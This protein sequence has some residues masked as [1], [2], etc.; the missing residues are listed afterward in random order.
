MI[1]LSNGARGLWFLHR[2]E[3][4]NATYNVPLVLRCTGELDTAA[5]ATAVVDLVARHEI[6]RTRMPE[7]DGEPVQLVLDPAEAP[8]MTVH[9]SDPEQGPALLERLARHC[10]D[11]EHEPA[12]RAELVRTGPRE[13]ALLLLAHHVATDGWSTTPLVHDLLTAYTARTAGS[14]PGWAEL[15]VQYGDYVLWQ[16]ELLGDQ[17]DEHSLLR[18]QLEHW[19]RVLDGAPEL[20]ALPTD[21]PRPSRPSRRGARTPL[22]VDASLRTAIAA[23]AARTR[24]TEFMVL[25]AALA[26]LLDRLG[27]GTDLPIGTSVAGRTEEGLDQLVGYFVNTLVLRTDT[28]GAPCFTEL[29]ARVRETDLAAYANQD[30]PFERLIHWLNPRRG[31]GHQP[32]SQIVLTMEDNATEQVRLGELTVRTEF[33]GT[34]AAKFDLLFL[35]APDAETGEIGGYLQYATELFDEETARSI[36][37]R[38]Q[39]LLAG[40][41][42]A[43]DRGID[44]AAVLSP[45]ERAV[46]LAAPRPRRVP[47]ED[48]ASAF[49]ERVHAHPD[50]IALVAGADGS[51]YTYARLDRVAEALAARLRAEDVRAEE[52]VAVRLRRGPRLVV[53]L[54]AV[55]KAGAAYVPLHESFP[56]ARVE[57]I[58]RD[59]GARLLLRDPG[60]EGHAGLR[61]LD[62]PAIED[63]EGSGQPAAPAPVHPERLAYVMY[64]SGSTGRPKG[65]AVTHADIL[66]LVSD[67]AWDG[68]TARRVLLHSSHAFD[69]S[70]FELWPPLLRGGRIICAPEGD[71]DPG[72]YRSLFAEYRPTAVF[73]TTALFELLAEDQPDCFAPV[74]Q[75][76]QGGEQVGAD[77]LRRVLAHCADT[78]LV[79]VYGPTETTTFATYQAIERGAE[80]GAPVPIGRPMDNR[81]ASVLDA[82]LRPVPPGVPGE[83][84]LSGSGLARGYLGDP[85]RTAERFLADPFG[86]PGT[87]MYR[88][89]DLVRW[90]RHGRIEFLGRDDK[91]VKLRGFRIELG[92]IETVLAAQD[93]VA[94][95]LV[96]VH[97][98]EAGQRRL[99]AYVVPPSGVNPDHAGLRSAL[100]GALPEY[101]VPAAITVLGSFPLNSNGKI[102]HAL[103]PAPE[104]G[105]GDRTGRPVTTD[106]EIL[107][108]LFAETLGLSEVGT[109]DGFFA[110]GG[111]SLLVMRLVARIEEVFSV[112]LPLA[113][114]FTAQTPSAVAVAVREA[115]ATER[116]ALVAGPRPERPPLSI[117]ANRLWFV[118]QLDNAGPAYH[119]PFVLR[120]EGELDREALCAAADDVLAR[121][122]SLRTAFPAEDGQPY[123]LIS[124]P[125][126]GNLPVEELAPAAVRERISELVRAPFDIAASPPLRAA[127]LAMSARSH[128]FVLV[129]HHILADGESLSVLRSDL[130]LAYNARR[131]GRA[132]EFAPLPVQYADYALWQRATGT[133]GDAMLERW[134]ARLRGAPQQLNLPT[135]HPRPAHAD[136]RGSSVTAHLGTEL[137]TALAG[138]AARTGSTL[139]MVLHAGL[140]ILLGKLGA[141]HDLPIG[142][143]VSGRTEP[144]TAALAGFFVNTVV[145]RTD[146][147]GDPRGTELLE[148]VRELDRQ[149]L[150]DQ[151]V[152]FERLVEALNPVRS[153][154]R[155]PLFQVMLAFRAAPAHR[156]AFDGLTVTEQEAETGTAKFDLSF[157]LSEDRDETGA[158]AG[159]HCT[160]RYAS[161]LFEERSA[162]EIAERYLR[163][164]TQLAA[165][166]ERRISTIDVLSQ[167]EHRELRV[168]AEH[169][170]RA[171]PDTTLPELFLDQARRTPDAVAVRAGDSELS[172]AGLAARASALARYLREHGVREGDLVAVAVSRR[173]ELPVALLG[174]QLAGAAYLPLD[175]AHPARRLRFI[176]A[177]A[178]PAFLISTGELDL[179]SSIPC[180]RIDEHEPDGAGTA[181]VPIRALGP[182]YVIY[183]SG[184]TGRPKG[185]RVSQRNLVNFLGALGELVPL[186]AEERLLAV[187]TVAFDIA[188]LELYLPLISGATV[189]LADSEDVRDPGALA[190]LIRAERIST[191]QATPALWEALLDNDQQVVRGLRALVGGE[192]LPAPLAARLLATGSPVRNLYGP[193]ETTIWST[194]A[195]LE[196]GNDGQA[197]PIGTP[198][199]NT[200]AHVLDAALRPVP[201]RVP[202]ELYLAGD[203]VADGYLGRPG[204]TAGRFLADPFGPPGTRMYRTGDLALREPDGTLHYLGR[205]DQQVKIRGFRIELG[206]IEAELVAHPSVGRAAAAVHEDDRTGTRIIAY[207]TG[208]PGV[209]PEP[210]AVRDHLRTRLPDYMLPAQYTVLDE[211]P[212]NP[213]GKLDRGALPAPER[214]EGTDKT[215]PR[216]PREALLCGLFAQ[217]L[218]IEG[219]GVHEDFFALGGH[220]LLVTTLVGRIRAECGEIGIRDVFEAPTVAGL[221]ARAG[222]AGPPRAP[223]R[224]VAPALRGTL[225]FAQQRLWFLHQFEGTSVAYNI[226]LALRLDACPNEDALRAALADVVLRHESLRTIFP[227][228]DGRPYQQVVDIEQAEVPFENL[229]GPPERL[230]EAARYEFDLTTELPVRA[231]LLRGPRPILLLVLHHIAADEASLGPL[232]HDLG[233]AYTARNTGSAPSL[234]PLPVQY[235]D[236]AHWQR[237][238][239]GDR[240]DTGSALATELAY[241]REALRGLSDELALPTDRP[242]PSAATHRGG[243]VHFTVGAET[244]DRITALARA[245][246]ATGFMVVHAALAALL[247]RIGAGTDIAIGTAVDG[248]SDPALAQVAGF[249]VNS[250]V[251]RADTSGRPRFTEL[252]DRVREADLGAYAHQEVPFEQLVEE[253]NPD[254]SA[255]RHPLFQVTL[256]VTADGN[257]LEFAADGLHGEAEFVR[258]TMAKFDLSFSLAEDENGFAGTLEFATDLFDT[259]TANSLAER[260]SRLLGE[261]TAAP[262]RRI[263]EFD[264]LS[265]AERNT[266]LHTWNTT[267]D[268]APVLELPRLFERQVAETPTLPA[269]SGPEGELSYAGLNGRANRI[270]HHLIGLGFGPGDVLACCLPRGALALAA[271]LGIAKAG[272]AYLPVDP[273]YP[274]DRIRHMLTDA[275]PGRVLTT[276]ALARAVPTGTAR[277]LVL[278]DLGVAAALDRL[279]GT[280]PD[281]DDRVTPLSSSATAYVIYTSGSSGRPKGVAVSHSGIGNSLRSLIARADVRAGERYLHFVSL[282]FDVSL[283]EIGMALVSGA[284]LVIPPER[285]AGAELAAFLERE[286]IAHVMLPPSMLSALPESGLRGLRSVIT[287]GETFAGDLVE[288][289]APGRRMINA[290]GPTEATMCAT[291]SQPLRPGEPAP[292]GSP[293][294]NTRC[295]VLDGDLQPVPPGGTGELYLAGTGLA[296]GYL[297][298]PGQTADRFLANPFGGPGERM[299]RTGDLVRWEAGGAL[300]FIGRADEQVKI[301]GYRLELGEVE[302]VLSDQ[303]GV[304]MAAAAVLERATGEKQLVGYVTP[305]P[306]AELDP[307]T[308]RAGALATLPDYM[309]PT[310]YLVLDALPLTPNGKVDRAALPAPTEIQQPHTAPR[311]QREELLCGIYTEL[312]GR[313]EVGIDE[314]FFALGGDSIL[315]IQL[316]SRARKAGLR[317][318]A[319]DVFQRGTV[320]ELAALASAGAP[321]RDTD[322]NGTGPLPALPIMRWLHELDGVSPRFS[323]SMLLSVPAGLD[324]ER[325]TSALGALLDTHD[326]L[327]L[328]WPEDGEPVVLPKGSID[329]ASVLHVADAREHGRE[330][331]WLGEQGHAAWRQLDPA[332]GVMLRCVWFDRGSAGPGALLLVLHHAAVDGI[333]WRILLPDLRAAYEGAAPEAV[334]TSLRT[335]SLWLHEEALRPGRTAELT[336]WERALTV[337]TA[338]IGRRPLD[339][340]TDTAGRAEEFT[341]VL[342]AEQTRALLTTVAARFNAGIEDVLLTAFAVALGKA[343]RGPVLVDVEGHG[344]QTGLFEDVDLSRTVGWF[345][346]SYPLLLEPGTADPKQG[347]AL[348][349]ALKAVKEQVRAVPDRGIGYGLLRYLNEETAARLRALPGAAAGFNYLGRMATAGRNQDEPGDWSVL[350][351]APVPP[352][353]GP[354]MPA[355][356]AIDVNALTEDRADGPYLSVTWMWQPGVLDE[357]A[358]TRLAA[359]FDEALRTL[360][361]HTARPDSGGLTPSDLGM[362]LD[363]DE[364]LDLEAELGNPE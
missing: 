324:R 23:L 241:W 255:A 201:P 64:T 94:A 59:T 8:A 360:V 336:F 165:A 209:R 205:T 232:L 97:E 55:L 127:L 264:L 339:P 45:A 21:H 163:V 17:D 159:L 144:A 32:Y 266:V 92:E 106:E 170:T 38:Y 316:V 143:P 195:L 218:G 220:S 348:G 10:F 100:A 129:L 50:A 93:S 76:W 210:D 15:P 357:A 347:T 18:E 259:G 363:Q 111:H 256:A 233:I 156:A 164:L 80:L 52:P 279:P 295:Y 298:Q 148:R 294:P 167:A 135:D 323:Q 359:D 364:I 334:P 317:F 257:R 356:H 105:S 305:G 250:I 138:L 145:L 337:P 142:T 330:P 239:L 344:R 343:A 332:A 151:Q 14:E 216:G 28:S 6:L 230:W 272:A 224:T 208:A 58:L 283:A 211:L 150:A 293:I 7:V 56:R 101:M 297:N 318:S 63:S 71:L 311:D 310:E 284:C 292:I 124:R 362:T 355:V 265:A 254:R 269:L 19:H 11:L 268:D 27:A 108:A 158:P 96:T 173:A 29:L 69:A 54:L 82:R 104:F 237:T 171:V 136:Y 137:H 303:D 183:T 289:W 102:D 327:R 350:P 33:L 277:A 125:R 72:V 4:P 326:A 185:V 235:A 85:R 35:L 307:A 193:T 39:R 226:P 338:P 157:A 302:A 31:L 245:H 309:V 286:H 60:G 280:D 190:R 331:A 263:S 207:L 240:A 131:A 199:W 342:G 247:T 258:T 178:A 290:Y 88:T 194:T 168:A 204:L 134:C 179:D 40:L 189:V 196:H 79:H 44:E 227:D 180:L 37:E 281:D 117:A 153:F 130:A 91:Q 313:A 278:D 126:R 228:V 155:H 174:T 341:T 214:R 123:Q 160:L 242:R 77:G 9:D 87:R 285:L 192:A 351:G 107:C 53:A 322:E 1:P 191:L 75:V 42:H 329:P 260:F 147:S 223:L 2:L 83:L 287:G 113:E 57:T 219:C 308:L 121:H 267:E 346:T 34:G 43:P 304:G 115:N 353:Q 78:K 166:P 271:I 181:P 81:R 184:S 236:Y 335:W 90:T 276:R 149:A 361:E 99:A 116:P 177:D 13:H 270:A 249:F 340:R 319:A 198:L 291:L 172:Y 20:L 12:F 320:R 186:E 30:V 212:L 229:D 187:T 253:L 328:R 49:T 162:K 95:A 222:R 67:S 274:A 215:P 47:A 251:L 176:L 273:D 333:S 141:G 248:R 68:E 169:T 119:V 306:G 3:G 118:D 243:L 140:A 315:S 213:N 65:V 5:L 197:P 358:V 252:I 16:Q 132:P 24:C 202:G 221:A 89:G 110:L 84:Y 288:R 154:A 120:L 188:A 139:F 217:V 128:V 46:V 74:G 62:V 231:S 206:E 133:G 114:V 26:V 261:L 25:H 275:A 234:P 301:R 146:A 70:T 98:D 161:A 314:G 244:R 22:H 300:R 225:S 122:E 86:P 262:Q 109:E 36:A 352:G 73:L 282:S 41:V 312:L 354:D 349:A 246:R 203:G 299:Y 66:A 51:E 296:I 48:V 345:T 112:R 175:P 182:A 152:P 61:A 200:R 238:V 321:R 325:L 103:L